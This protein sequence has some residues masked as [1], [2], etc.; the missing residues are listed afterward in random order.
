MVA[1]AI[2][3]I[4]Q[5]SDNPDEIRHTRVTSTTPEGSHSHDGRADGVLPWERSCYSPRSRHIRG[6]SP[7]WEHCRWQHLSPWCR[8]NSANNLSEGC[9]RNRQEPVRAVTTNIFTVDYG[10]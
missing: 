5:G 3:A 4:Q 1:T 2:D 10:P 6:G 8:G 7:L 9:L